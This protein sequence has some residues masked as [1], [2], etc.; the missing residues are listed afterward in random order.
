[1][2]E[3]PQCFDAGQA[4]GDVGLAFAPGATERVR[5]HDADVRSAGSTER[6]AQSLGRTVRVWRQ[7]RRAIAADVGAID[8]RVGAHQAMVRFADD[9]ATLHAHDAPALA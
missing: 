1:A 7:Q 4:D 9:H 3:V 6:R 5:D 8:A 2:L